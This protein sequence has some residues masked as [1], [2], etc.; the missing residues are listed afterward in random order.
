MECYLFSGTVFVSTVHRRQL[1]WLCYCVYQG[2]N[3]YVF[4]NQALLLSTGSQHRSMFTSLQHFIQCCCIQ[5][6]LWSFLTIGA[7]STTAIGVS[8]EELFGNSNTGKTVIEIKLV[9][10]PYYPR[11]IFV[12]WS[13]S[14]NMLYVTSSGIHI[15]TIA[16][17]GGLVWHVL[18]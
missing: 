13:A 17:L 3:F 10:M 1:R 2:D 12:F 11:P 14:V 7:S 15:Y 6:V 5:L 8:L 4:P 9:C 18:F 16:F